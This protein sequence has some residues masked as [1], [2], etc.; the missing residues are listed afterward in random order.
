MRYQFFCDYFLVYIRFQ[1]DFLFKI[2]AEFSGLDVFLFKE[3]SQ[4]E[5]KANSKFSIIVCLLIFK[6]IS[7]MKI[8]SEFVCRIL[9]EFLL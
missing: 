8:L 2:E 1:R 3:S 4:I 9:K 7:F 5:L 6:G